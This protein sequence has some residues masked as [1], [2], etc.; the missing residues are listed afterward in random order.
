MT[1]KEA[2]KLT[3]EST[4][5]RV[6]E[7]Y[8]NLSKDIES[9]AYGGGSW[10]GVYN[11]RCC[12]ENKIKLQADGFIVEDKENEWLSETNTEKTYIH[13]SWAH[14]IDNHAE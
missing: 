6:I 13:I 5:R 2:A 8:E 3:I 11:F 14:L 12:E 4:P 9:A 1:A 10:I 7:Q